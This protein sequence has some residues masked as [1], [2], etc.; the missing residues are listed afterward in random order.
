M[1][2]FKCTKDDCIHMGVNFKRC[3]TCFATSDIYNHHPCYEPESDVKKQE[4]V[5]EIVADIKR[6]SDLVMVVRCKDCA[7]YEANCCFNPQWDLESSTELP[8]VR[9]IDF[10]SYGERKDGAGE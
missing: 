10:C 3:L 8:L 9:E 4:I 1:Y 5:N 2:E 7:Y 6:F